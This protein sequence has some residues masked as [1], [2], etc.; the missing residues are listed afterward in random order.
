M[1]A[2]TRTVVVSGSLVGLTLQE[3]VRVAFP[4]L[5]AR[6]VFKKCRTGEIR[7]G[8]RRRQPLERVGEAE[9]IHVT[10]QVP[11]APLLK[12]ILF[13]N[14]RVETTAGPLMVLREDEDLLVAAKDSG[15]ASHPALRRSGDTLLERVLRYLPP[16]PEGD[17]KPALANRLD[18]E[19]SGIV[20][21][22]KNQASRRHLGHDLQKRR[23]EKRY[24]ALVAGE[25]PSEGDITLPLLQKPD[26]RDLA[27]YPAGH[28]K[29]NPK[30]LSAHTRYRVL[31]TARNLI[32][33]SLVEIELITG[34]T[35]QIRRHFAMIGHPVAL[36]RTWGD[37]GFNREIRDALDLDRMFLHS[38]RV[39]LPHPTTRHII[40]ICAPMSP[41]LVHC[42]A[43]LGMARDERGS[44]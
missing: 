32:A 14:R 21:V 37:G 9:I 4:Q 31:Q 6:E 40:E 36:D 38:A 33:A 8:D 10:I 2:V 22:G 13:E 43:E 5:G 19:T 18:I 24:L 42:L 17:F 16:D 39:R 29:L 20:L 15:C 12:P 11:E 41:E 1:E 7:V 3:V 28:E 27:R 26:S 34:R 35:H 30:T 23:I 25:P 44:P